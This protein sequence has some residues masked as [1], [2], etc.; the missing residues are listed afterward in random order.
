MVRTRLTHVP[1]LLLASLLAA[2][3]ALSSAW[4]EIIASIHVT[5]LEQINNGIN[6]Q[7]GLN[8]LIINSWDVNPNPHLSYSPE[9][10]NT[11]TATINSSGSYNGSTLCASGSGS[12]SSNFSSG[13]SSG[14]TI[15]FTP[16]V[17]CKYYLTL[18]LS[19]DIF[20]S[21]FYVTS[22]LYFRGDNPNDNL[23][24]HDVVTFDQYKPI[25]FEGTGILPAGFEY[26]FSIG[27]N[28][29]QNNSYFTGDAGRTYVGN[30]QFNLKVQPVPV[31]SALLLLGSGLLGLLGVGRFWKK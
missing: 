16:N 10:G 7:N 19:G 21:G 5:A 26:I 23:N 27:V 14:F 24:A 4:A 31:P 29:T 2:L 17:D 11:A 28:E 18:S 12:A 13:A 30:W 25:N 8:N 9:Q 22:V 3:V 15:T 6:G 20:Q 1:C